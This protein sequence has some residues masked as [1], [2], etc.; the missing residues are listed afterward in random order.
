[1]KKIIIILFILLII[2]TYIF[3]NMERTFKVCPTRG[4]IYR[5]LKQNRYINIWFCN[6][7][8]EWIGWK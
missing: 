2:L 7:K 5:E 4:I 1:M 8:T 3:S 6:F